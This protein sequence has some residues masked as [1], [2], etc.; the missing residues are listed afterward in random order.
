VE[1]L[2]QAIEPHGNIPKETVEGLLAPHPPGS[3]LL[4]ARNVAAF[5][6]TG[7]ERSR[8][9]VLIDA[10]RRWNPP[11]EAVKQNGGP[12]DS[13]RMEHIRDELIAQELARWDSYDERDKALSLVAF[14]ELEERL[15]RVGS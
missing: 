14:P 15:R 3:G 13:D 4:M 6:F 9:A 12:D 1:I 10:L 5:R 7:N 2:T 11:V 8:V